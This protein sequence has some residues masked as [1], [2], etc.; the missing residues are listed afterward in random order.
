[1]KTAKLFGNW[2][3]CLSV[4]CWVVGCAGEEVET[5]GPPTTAGSTTNPTATG[6]HGE[7]E[8]EHAE[9]E[10]EHEH[11][12]GE[13]TEGETTEGETTEGETTEGETSGDTS[14]AQ[15][16]TDPLEIPETA[17]SDAA[18]GELNLP[19]VEAGSTTGV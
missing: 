13:T 5:E 19:A 8:H 4:V 3:I 14:E 12:E 9:G 7:G 15:S 17:T 11:A 18:E 2:L 16:S 1:M 10:G 6:T